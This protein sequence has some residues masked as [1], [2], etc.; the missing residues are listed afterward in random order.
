MGPYAEGGREGL[1]RFIRCPHPQE[2]SAVIE[3]LLKVV[4]V[5][6]LSVRRNHSII[7]PADA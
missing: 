6:V 4:G 3:L 7:R 2:Q 5:I 1:V